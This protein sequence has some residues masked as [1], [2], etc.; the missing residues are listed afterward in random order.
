MRDRTEYFKQ[1]RQEHRAKRAAYQ[2]A[3][4]AKQA[5]VKFC[6]DCGEERPVVEFSRNPARKSGLNTYCKQHQYAR[7]RKCRES[8]VKTPPPQ[9][10][11]MFKPAPKK[12]CTCHQ[13]TTC[14]ICRN[15]E[16]RRA[17]RAGELPVYRV[18]MIAA[19]I[20][21]TD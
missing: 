7:E 17:F 15:T 10:V 2:R 14:M 4:R 1:W 20:A 12:S 9:Q 18:P 6:P 11:D 8:H 5:G 13:Y 3:F 16:K 21:G 19:A